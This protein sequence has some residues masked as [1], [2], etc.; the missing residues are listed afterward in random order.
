MNLVIIGTG[1]SLVPDRARTIIYINAY[2]L[3]INWIHRNQ[4]CWSFNQKRLS[5]IQQP[6]F[7]NA[8]WQWRHNGYDCV[9]NHQPHQCLINRLFGHRRKKTSKLRVPGLYEFSGDRWIPRTNDQLRGNV[10]IWWC[11]HAM[12][13]ISCRLNMISKLSLMYR[14][15]RAGRNGASQELWSRIT[16]KYTGRYF[17]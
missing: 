6:S 11:H 12:S 17:D 4:F 10:S 2:L 1:N 16:S 8:Q 3:S 5:L 13:A 14:H 15:R 7:G 9:S